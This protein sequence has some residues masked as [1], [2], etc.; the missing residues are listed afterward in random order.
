MGYDKITLFNLNDI[1]KGIFE[2][3]KNRFLV[4]CIYEGKTI[5]AHLPNPGRLWEL[6][7]KERQVYLTK[8]KNT[9]YKPRNTEFTLVAVLKDSRPICLHTQKTN[10]IARLLIEKKYIHEFEGYKIEKSEVSVNG[11][12]FDFLLKKGKEF[13]LLE[14]KSC[15]L[16]NRDFAMFPDA[17]TLRGKRHITSLAQSQ[18]R[19]GILFIVQS[20][21]PDYF[22]PEYHIDPEFARTL[23]LYRDK[24]FI[25][26]VGIGWND[27]LTFK[28]NIKILSI[29]WDVYEREGKDAGSYLLV[30]KN[31]DDK[32]IKIGKLGEIFFKKGFYIYVGSAMKNL[33]A[34]LNRHK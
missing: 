21:S 17:V 32:K 3:R 7:Q 9:L 31:N 20:D 24:I 13:M 34:R 1:K 2:K 5:E 4:E 11:N 30:L 22:L 33:Q 8:E 12:R 19:G 10:E 23:Y 15:T 14:V 28:N 18:F 25:K 29:P 27:D 26:A 6:L 16:F